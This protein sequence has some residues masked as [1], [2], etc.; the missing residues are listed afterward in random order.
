M[1]N[2]ARQAL[3]LVDLA[4]TSA[5]LDQPV[6]FVPELTL[7]RPAACQVSPSALSLLIDGSDGVAEVPEMKAMRER[8]PQCRALRA[9]KRAEREEQD[10]RYV[11]EI[12]LSRCVNHA[13]SERKARTQDQ[14]QLLHQHG[15]F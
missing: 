11:G 14:H 13:N 8:E 5:S 9:G 7:Q 12:C 3:E 10:E 15:G 4:R 1:S 6:G 2:C